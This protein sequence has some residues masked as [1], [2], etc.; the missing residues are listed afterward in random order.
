TKPLGPHIKILAA[1]PLAHPALTVAAQRAP[2][3]VRTSRARAAAVGPGLVPALH[4]IRAGRDAAPVLALAA[5]AV[6]VAATGLVRPAWRARAA[7]V[8]VRLVPVLHLVIAGS[9]KTRPPAAKL[10]RAV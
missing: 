2:V 7:A 9:G 6:G 10:A 4:A 5:L 3:P 1:S 8:D